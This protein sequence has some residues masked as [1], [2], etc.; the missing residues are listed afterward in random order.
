M[1]TPDSRKFG[2]VPGRYSREE[3]LQSF[4]GYKCSF[5]GVIYVHEKAAG[6][7]QGNHIGRDIHSNGLHAIR[8]ADAPMQGK[9][10]TRRA[11]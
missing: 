8:W 5:V 6:M 4:Q 10:K 9:N 1:D 7:H 3:I 11:L 2:I